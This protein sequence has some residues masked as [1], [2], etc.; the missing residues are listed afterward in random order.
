[1]QPDDGKTG[2]AEPSVIVRNLGM[3]KAAAI[4]MGVLIIV[5]TAVVIGTIASRLAK[6]SAPPE[7]LSLT[8]PD[9]RSIRSASADE[10]GFVLIVDGPDGREIWRLSPD[11]ARQQTIQ[12]V[13]E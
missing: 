4:I 2:G 7:T 1:M 9:G 8:I 11:G 10:G 5:L 12:I 6:M 3:I 13:T